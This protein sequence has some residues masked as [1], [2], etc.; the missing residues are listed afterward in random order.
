MVH[1]RMYYYDV[2]FVSN[3]KVY[4]NSTQYELKLENGQI[5]KVNQIL[6]GETKG[7]GTGTL[8]WPAAHVL[9]KYLEKRFLSVG[10][11]FSHPPLA[12]KRVCDVGSGT[13]ITGF[14]AAAMGA[15]VT[16]TDQECV[17][18]LLKE[19]ANLYSLAFSP[20]N[21]SNI[22]I[23]LYEWGADT[24]HLGLPFDFILVSDCVLPKLYPIEILV[25]VRS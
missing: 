21:S 16:L 20:T 15:T 4:L 1:W 14:V 12:G 19:N 25:K 24:D 13:G 10:D 23:E 6:N 3:L 8:V 7:L 18:P 11:S 2:Y 17:M 22:S 5:I 9:S